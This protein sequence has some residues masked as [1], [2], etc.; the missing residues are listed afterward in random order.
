[1]KWGSVVCGEHIYNITTQEPEDCPEF[2][3]S[4][5]HLLGSCLK[6]KNNKRQ[7]KQTNKLNEI[8]GFSSERSMLDRPILQIKS[9]L[10][11]FTV[12]R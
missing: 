3:D 2:K 5:G 10:Q 7:G 11:L 1:M 9:S 8:W 4:L 6:T 12:M